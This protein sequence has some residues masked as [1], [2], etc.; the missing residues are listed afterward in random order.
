MYP[1]LRKKYVRRK[2]LNSFRGYDHRLRAAEGAFYETENLSTALCP[3]LT[4]RKRRGQYAELS[5]AQGLAAKDAP[6][7]VDDGTLYY[8]GIATGLTGLSAGEKQLVSMGAYL[9]IFPD[10]RYF[11]TADTNDFGSMEAAWTYTGSVRYAL[12]TAE[13]VEPENVFESASEPPAPDD[14]DYWLDTN[15]H[16]LSCWSAAMEQWIEPETCYTKAEFTSEGQLPA[17]FSLYDGVRIEGLHFPSLNGSKILYGIG[18]DGDNRDYIVLQGEPVTGGTFANER[19]S[20][21]RKVPEMDFVC[22]C[23]NRLW[24]C[25]YGNDGHGN[26]NELY[27]CALGDFRNWEKFMGLSTDSWRAGVGSDGVWTGAVNYLGTPIFFKENCLHRVA[28]SAEGAHSVEETVCR[29]VEKDSSKSLVVVDETLFYKSLSDVC[30]YQGGF[31]ESISAPFGDRRYHAAVA[32]SAD[33]KYYISLLDENDAPQLFVY[34][35]RHGLWCREDGL[36][37]ESFAAVDN[38][39]FCLSENRIYDLGGRAGEMEERLSWSAE[40]GL[41][42]L[43]SGDGKYI[44]RILARMILMR[45]AQAEIFAEYES[46][47][48]WEY[49]GR[50]NGVTAGSVEIPLRVRRCDHLRL[51]LAGEGEMKLLSLET[52]YTEG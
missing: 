27:A 47:G 24:G 6:A 51:K 4:T 12:C 2:S 50:V 10:K 5:S 11:N 52:E 15:D 9:C 49:L 25:R 43:E 36:R 32:G 13:G 23:R 19:V 16:V 42:G 30:I 17:R 21:Q 39:L 41:L 26:L 37:A 33:R 40:T 1:K 8:N 3:L 46:S 45:G 48:N 31:P 38:E 34:D 18:G 29:G 14:G 7:W 20:I 35:L 44:S 28:V 22:Q